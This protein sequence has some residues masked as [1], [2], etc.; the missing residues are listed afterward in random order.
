[1]PDGSFAEVVG[2]ASNL[3]YGAPEAGVQPVVYAS[4]RQVPVE[5]PTFIVRTANDP[6]SI[7]PAIRAELRLLNSAVPIHRVSTVGALGAQALGSTRLVTSVLSVFA[8]FAVVLS[9]FGIYAVIAYA[10]S[11]RRRE[12]G[13][14]VA[15]GASAPS[16]V[17]FVLRQG[18]FAAGIGVA[19]GL[20]G[21]WAVARLLS[22]LLFEVS[23]ADPASFGLAASLLFAVALLASYL[24]ARRV[25]RVNPI[26]VLRAE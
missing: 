7:L 8:T 19:V 18:A 24:P 4:A 16:V 13:I 22:S 14:R 3:L 2:V 9:V 23:A 25:T 15:L 26:E 6:L 5:N 21:A 20:A 10:V 1:M 17:R 12:I 11:R